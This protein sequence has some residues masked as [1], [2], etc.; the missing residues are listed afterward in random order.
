V[1][2]TDIRPDCADE[3]GRDRTKEIK[4]ASGIRCF[5]RNALTPALSLLLIRPYSVS[6][7]VSLL[8]HALSSSLI[9]SR[10]SCITHSLAHHLPRSFIISSTHSY[11]LTLPLCHTWLNPTPTHPA[12]IFTHPF[13]HHSS[14]FHSFTP[15]LMTSRSNSQ[16]NH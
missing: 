11:S 12:H 2:R 8:T 13:S 6:L 7:T 16:T 10:Q 5:Q 1:F 3:T 9:I 15:S 4:G 14:L